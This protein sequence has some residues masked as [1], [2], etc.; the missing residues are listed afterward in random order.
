MVKS[1]TLKPP[2]G[3][4]NLAGA[5]SISKLFTGDASVVRFVAWLAVPDGHG[6]GSENV[7]VLGN[8]NDVVGTDLVF[9]GLFCVIPHLISYVGK[10][11]TERKRFFPEYTILDRV[12]MRSRR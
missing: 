11:Q 9:D 10:R 12:A 6:V 8:G 4:C 5:K 1:V 7:V 3:G 2:S